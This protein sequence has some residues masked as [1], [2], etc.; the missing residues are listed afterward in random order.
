MKQ[1]HAFTL[2]ELLVVIAII[3]VLVALLLPAVQQ[4]REAARRMQCTNGQ[5]QIVLAMHNYEGSFGVYPTGRLGC[6]G[7]CSPV[8]GPSTS[9]FVLLLPF[10]EQDNLYQQFAPYG[11]GIDYIDTLP[12]AVVNNRPDAYVCPS[13]TM[14]PSFE[15]DD[16][17]WA[18]ASYALVSGHYG[19][20]E[21]TG[22]KVKWENS[23]MFVYRDSYRNRDALDGLS[24]VM[25]VGEVIDGHLT[26]H[27][28]RWTVGTRHLDSLRTTENPVNTP[29]GEGITTSPYGQPYNGAFGSR[30]PGGANFGFGDGSVHFLA[31]TINLDVYKLLSQRASGQVKASDA[32]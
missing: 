29:A 4:A 2:V 17:L 21:Q 5:K 11:P 31:E 26:N 20:S 28:N 13:S 9:G 14:A 3:G 22:P 30:H 27:L 16:K 24:N 10:L 8:N 23:G 32:Y 18:T 15:I 19:P 7:D 6:D 1:R 12:E 25:F